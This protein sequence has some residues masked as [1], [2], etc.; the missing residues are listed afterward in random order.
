MRLTILGLGLAVI[1]SFA[2][3]YWIS[4][5]EEVERYGDAQVGMSLFEAQ[6]ALK[7]D[8]WVSF[9]GLGR[10]STKRLKVC[11]EGFASTLINETRRGY[12]LILRTNDECKVTKIIRRVRKIEA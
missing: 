9:R 11:G 8:G 4:S 5:D 12:T 6:S 10:G 7:D 1:C 2:A 3:V